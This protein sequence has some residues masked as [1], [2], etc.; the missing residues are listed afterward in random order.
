MQGKL[1]AEHYKWDRKRQCAVP[2]GLLPLHM[3]HFVEMRDHYM[4]ENDK[5]E[6]SKQLSSKQMTRVI[7]SEYKKLTEDK[8]KK[9][10]KMREQDAKRYS[11][12]MEEFEKKGHFTLEDGT[13]STAIKG[14]PGLA[15]KRRTTTPVKKP[16]ARKLMP[17]K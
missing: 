17:K 14:P 16:A 2:R 3:Y 15:K 1:N 12:Q 7:R 5:R 9:Y 4:R 10:V 6:N 13:K 11:T 8:L